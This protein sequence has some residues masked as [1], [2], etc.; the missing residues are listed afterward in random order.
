MKTQKPKFSKG[1]SVRIVEERS[2]FHRGYKED[3]TTE[4]FIITKVLTNLP[5]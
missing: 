5:I 3:F 2:T 1:D 4:T